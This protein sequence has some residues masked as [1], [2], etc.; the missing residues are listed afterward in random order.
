MPTGYYVSVI[1]DRK[2][3]LVLGPYAAH[4]EALAN[5]AIGRQRAEEADPMAVF[6]SFGTCK[7]ETTKPL[8]NG[9]LGK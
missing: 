7:I 9:V 4:S 5:V 6:Y 3:G 1:N 8:P 2:R